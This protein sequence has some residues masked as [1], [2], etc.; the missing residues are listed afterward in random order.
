[1][2]RAKEGSQQQKQRERG[3]ERVEERGTVH[4]LV[5]YILALCAGS[6]SRSQLDG[7]CQVQATQLPS[8]LIR[9]SWLSAPAAIV[10]FFQLRL[11]RGKK[12]CE[13][14]EKL[15]SALP[16]HHFFYTL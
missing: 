2:K 10:P 8:E 3:R 12:A 11:E 1:M 16:F 6:Q 15:P 14:K 5:K 9:E 7:S 13:Y 4:I